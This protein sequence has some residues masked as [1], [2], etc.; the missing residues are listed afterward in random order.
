LG[1][2]LAQAVASGQVSDI[3][4]ARQAVAES[5]EQVTYEP[6][7]NHGWDEAFGRFKD[8]TAKSVQS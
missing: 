2:V 7:Q 3:Q 8:V 5:M 1:N 4:Q 6:R